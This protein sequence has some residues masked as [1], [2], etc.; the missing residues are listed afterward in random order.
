MKG[1]EGKHRRMKTDAVF[2]GGG[3]RAIA[4]AGAVCC[5]EEH[6][7][8]WQGIAG[9]SAGS[10]VCSAARCKVIPAGNLKE[11]IEGLDYRKFMDKGSLQSVPLV[12]SL[13]GLLIHKRPQLWQLSGRVD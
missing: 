13:L 9:T 4:F 1:P 7:Y 5:F 3:V 2:E 10:I 11:I 12:G 6:G 8:K